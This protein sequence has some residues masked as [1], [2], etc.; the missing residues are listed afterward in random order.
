MLVLS[1]GFQPTNYL[2]HLEVVGRAGR[3]LQK[4][5]DGEPR[6]FLGVTVPTFPNF[7]MLYGPGTNGGEIALNLRNQAAYARRAVKRMI[8]EGVTAIEVKRSWA[9]PYHAWLQ[10]KMAGTAWAVSNNYFTTSAGKIVTQWPFSALDYGALL[11][12]LGPLSETVRRRRA[13]RYSEASSIPR[14]NAAA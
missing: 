13:L 4:Y 3:T 1:T 9:D 8:R 6:A 5:W 14:A 11:K 7:Y 10:S 2:A 12:T